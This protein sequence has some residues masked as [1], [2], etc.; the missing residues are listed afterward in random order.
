MISYEQ[1]EKLR[2][3]GWNEEEISKLLF[4]DSKNE[5]SKEQNEPETEEPETEEPGTE[6]P[7]P[8]QDAGSVEE[9]TKVVNAAIAEFKKGISEEIEELKKAYQKHNLLWANN[10]KPEGAKDA[11]GVLAEMLQVPTFQS[12][13]E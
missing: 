11:V 6:E 10:S 9:L 13:K 7:E 12:K 8:V 1:V 4:E 3:G 2:A 5:P